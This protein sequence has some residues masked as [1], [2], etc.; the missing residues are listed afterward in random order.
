MEYDKF[1]VL[2]DEQEYTFEEF[3]K[4]LDEMMNNE[5]KLEDESVSSILAM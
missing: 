3:I 4:L 1:L 2:D 5:T